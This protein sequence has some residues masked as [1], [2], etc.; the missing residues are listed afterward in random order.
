M[1]RFRSISLALLCSTL[2]TVACE[3][4]K[5]ANPLSPDVA[6]PIPG[7]AIT[8]PRPLEPPQGGQVVKNGEP[9]TLLIENPSTSGQRALFLQI[10]L[11]ADT[12]FQ[13]LVHHAERV[14][15]G[16]NGRT[17]YRLPEQLG[18]GYTYYW[19]LRAGD[20]AN[21]GPYSPTYQFTVVDPVVM[22]TPAPIEPVGNITTN[23]PT[24]RVRNGQI[25]G[26]TGAYYRFE[27]ATAP[28]P[29]AIVAVVTTTPGSDGETSISLGDLPYARTFYWRVHASDGTTQSNYSP[30]ISFTTPPAPAP[31]PP[32]A[33]GPGPTP[34]PSP[35]P[36]PGGP[37]GRTPDPPPGQRL[38][39]PNM[40]HVVQQVAASV[41]NLNNA[42]CGSWYFLD[43][44]VD[45][46]RT[47]DTRWGYNWKR[48]NVGDPSHDV[49]DYHWSAGPDE[50]STQVY[51]IDVIGAHCTPG[52]SPAWIDVTD[53]T[54][55]NGGVGRWTGRG[56]F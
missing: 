46:L 27:L 53:A 4:A 48:G 19:R 13:Q 36:L 29:S 12:N 56:R 14:E 34:G 41:G 44:L 24:F 23:K 25:S 8:S 55:N 54:Y 49:V 26:T 35:A 22:E 3:R 52:A 51:I 20:G 45:T 33:P 21:M 39:L 30:L 5:S 28:D 2:A 9:L 17:T 10:E 42:S 15:P 50:G 31:P 18:A 38:P 37:G 16:A 6:G 1:T 7:V 47:Y 11:A 43:L 32:P 40:L